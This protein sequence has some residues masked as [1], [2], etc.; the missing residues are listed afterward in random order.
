[1]TLEEAKKMLEEEG[2]SLEGPGKPSAVSEYFL[3]YESPD[4]C[5]AMQIVCSAGYFVCME[6]SC[7]DERKARLQKEYE[8]NTKA[9]GSAENRIKEDSGVNPAIKEA[10]SQ[11]ND[12]LLDEQAKKIKRLGKE[13]SRLN[14]IIHDKNEEIKRKTKGCCELVAENVD[15]KEDLRNTESL[16]HDTREANSRNLDT[17][18]KNEDLID[19][20]KKKLVEKTKLA[21]KYAKELSDSS[22]DLCKLEK[23]LK[24]KDAVLSDVAEELR[25]TRIREKNLAELGLKYVGE[26]EKL[27]KKLADKIVDEIDARALK[28]AESALAYKE[29]VI[30]EKD[31][32][33]ADL[34]KELAATKKELEGT[35]N[36]VRMVRNA[37]KEYCEY[38]IAAEKMIQKLSKIIV[39][40]G[41]VPSDVFEKCR[42]WAKGYRFNPQLPEIS[43]EEEKKLSSGRDTHP[44]DSPVEIGVDKGDEDG[45]YFGKIVRCGKDF[46]KILKEN[47]EAAEELFKV[48][49]DV[50]EFMSVESKQLFEGDGIP[51]KMEVMEPS[52]KF[53]KR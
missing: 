23:Q 30:A 6:M 19:E 13:I 31:E 2:F 32:V 50:I 40:K 26:N 12:A 9:P 27:K 1:M 43:E 7:F 4:I 35:N 44:T 46:A 41:L 49:D 36:L 28:S 45:D 34:G 18:F 33:I 29:K 5:E 15:L 38:G 48:L 24:D 39:S 52:R 16:L 14:D 10:A 3:K 37:S 21:K 20:L 25:L 42:L 22:L 53:K 17:C 11:F 47:E 8:E 51:T